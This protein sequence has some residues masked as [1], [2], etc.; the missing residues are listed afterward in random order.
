MFL[1]KPALDPAVSYVSSAPIANITENLSLLYKRIPVIQ[2]YTSRAPSDSVVEQHIRQN[3]S[4]ITLS[5]PQYKQYRDSFDCS[6]VL[7]PDYHLLSTFGYSPD[8]FGGRP[9]IVVTSQTV[10]ADY[11]RHLSRLPLCAFHITAQKNDRFVALFILSRLYTT[12]IF[13]RE[14]ERVRIFCELLQISGRVY[15]YDDD[16]SHP[17]EEEC[18]VFLDGPKDVSAERCFVVDHRPSP[19]IEELRLDM[20]LAGKYKYRIQDLMRRLSPA[21]VS[22]RRALDLSKFMGIAK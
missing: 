13:T 9:L 6:H 19:D 18:A 15:S 16:V 20:A 12:A 21:V 2:I 22:G 3:T 7:V 17:I 4:P 14:A 11:P 10:H 5:I 1:Q 8:D